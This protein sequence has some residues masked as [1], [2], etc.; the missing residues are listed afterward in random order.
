MTKKARL[1]YK[2][3]KFILDLE[4]VKGLKRIFGLMFSSR[5]KT[6]PLLFDFEKMT[7]RPIHS[8]FVFFPFVVIWLDDNNKIVDFKLVK[9]FSFSVSP[10][11]PYTKL[12]E[13][14]LNRQ[15]S[16]IMK[17]LVGDRKV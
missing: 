16:K 13:V 3:H 7:T 5:E 8:L 10:S 9:P 1:T 15:Y 12:I 2:G 11:R 17:I 4:V 6:K 14:P